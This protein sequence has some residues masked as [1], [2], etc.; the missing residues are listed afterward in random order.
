MVCSD[1]VCMYGGCGA[2][3]TYLIVG[4]GDLSIAA[5]VSI[6][7]AIYLA[8][9]V[10]GVGMLHAF[11][12]RR[13][14]LLSRNRVF[15]GFLAVPALTALI[16]GL[17]VSSDAAT[18]LKLWSD[19]PR[20]RTMVMC[21]QPGLDFRYLTRLRVWCIS[22][23]VADAMIAAAMMHQLHSIR[24]PNNRTNGLIRRLMR[25]TILSGAA[26]GILALLSGT[27]AHDAQRP[28]QR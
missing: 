2:A 17:V 8:S 5:T 13:Y 21:V 19:R 23:V 26:P 6:N 25:N 15:S 10:V 18:K 22:S 9:L 12:I 20:E 11:L 1:V 7:Y 24:V 28:P 14:L 16:G 27:Q 3:Y 4:W